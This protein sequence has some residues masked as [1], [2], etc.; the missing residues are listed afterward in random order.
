MLKPEPNGWGPGPA[1]PAQSRGGASGLTRRL[2]ATASL[3]LT[4]RCSPV[5]VLNDLAPDYLVAEGIAYGPEL[6]QRLDVYAP[7]PRRRPAPVIVFLYGGG[8]TEGS[9]S[10]Y[11][12]VGGALAEAGAVVVIP[13]Y[14]LYP[15]VRFPGFVQDCARATAWA[16]RQAAAYG[17]A[18]APVLMGHSAGAYNAA[19]LGLDPQWL[20]AAGFDRRLLRGVIGLAGPYDFLP[21]D[22]D[23]LRDIFGPP[24]REHTQPVAFVDAAAPAFFLAAGSADRTVRPRN[25]TALAA[26]LR[27]SGRPVSERIY[28][29][30][31][32]REIIGAL[33]GPLRFL[34][35]T[36]QDTCGFVGLPRSDY[37]AI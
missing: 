28:P 29:G 25:T 1:A 12:F 37:R 35:P 21:L 14:R 15:A 2:F 9:R 8:W 31:D 17:G 19:M 18:G 22:T 6:R 24:P 10:L 13:D 3:L 5:R 34:A 11:R 7:P 23:Q 33:A 36:Y 20:G 32:H 16:A 26:R 4:A 27:A 30:V